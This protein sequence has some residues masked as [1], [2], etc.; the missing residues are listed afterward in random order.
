MKSVKNYLD[1]TLKKLYKTADSSLARGRLDDAMAAVASAAR[2]LYAA[3]VRY[4]D[5][6]AEELLAKIVAQLPEPK[7]GEAV[8]GR[9]LFYD[10]FGFNNRGLV[11]IYL[12][13]LGKQGQL[14]Y[15]THARNRENLPDVVRIVEDCGGTVVW[16]TGNTMTSLAGEISGLFAQQLPQ[17]AFLYTMPNDVPALAAFQRNGG[18]AHRYQINLTD[19]AYW[20]GT[21]AFDT[22]IEFRDYG[23]SISRD[24]RAIPAE[25]LAKV[26]FYP[27]IDPNAPF[28]GYPFP[29]SEGMQVVFS[30]GSLYKTLGGGNRYYAM[31]EFIL[32]EF[33]NALFWYAGSG[34]ASQ[35]NILIEKY[36]SRVFHTSERSDL[37]Q[38]LQHSFLYLS[39]YPLCGGLMFQYAASA[40]KIPVTLRYDDV[41]DDFL[42]DQ[43]D[44]GIQF[45]TMEEVEQELRKLFT[46][47]DYRAEKERRVKA[48]VLDQTAFEASVASLLRTGDSGYQIRFKP[49]NTKEFLDEYLDN[50]TKNEIAQ[51]LVNKKSLCLLRS[52]P[53][54]FIRGAAY[55]IKSKLEEKWK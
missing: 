12:K 49:V 46:D 51:Y 25:K 36:P 31:A 15:V 38:V 3:N 26:P 30:G 43:D 50:L 37:F 32:K 35:L 41:S 29:V 34:D 18:C 42:L 8:S 7:T 28:Q 4:T 44:L 13:A 33:P 16:L 39:T 52:M 23:A 20:L 10:G 19:H 40:G 45:A 53:L 47:P 54:G 27:A 6:V 55:K 21:A 24:K 5:P 14:I 2:I 48:A 22:C 1:S 9:I 17:S 11:Q